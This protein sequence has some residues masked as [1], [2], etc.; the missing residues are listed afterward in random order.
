MKRLRS[1]LGS[2][3]SNCCLQP[4]QAAPS[5]RAFFSCLVRRRPSSHFNSD[6]H[7]ARLGSIA[8]HLQVALEKRDQRGALARSRVS[9]RYLS[10]LA[11]AF[12]AASRPSNLGEPPDLPSSLVRKLDGGDGTAVD[13]LDQSSRRPPRRRLSRISLLV[14]HC[15]TAPRGSGAV[16]A[17]CQ[18]LQRGPAP[19]AGAARPRRV[20]HG[21]WAQLARPIQC[22]KF[23]TL[24]IDDRLGLRY[25]PS[26]ARRS[27]R[28]RCPP[29][30]PPY[31][32]TRR[33]VR[34][35]L[36]DIARDR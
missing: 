32:E 21:W 10:R 5:P 22:M 9:L 35:L 1:S 12:S 2:L 16:F 6:R 17:F 8:L 3:G 30:R 33:P 26:G 11:Y 31:R 25:A 36:L 18:R 14:S 15:S 13:A 24:G 7:L 28:S 20:A 34:H 19:R 29:D 27:W 23:T 4:L